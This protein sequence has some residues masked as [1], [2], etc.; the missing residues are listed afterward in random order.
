MIELPKDAEGKSIPLDTEEL[1]TYDG[2]KQDV[3]SFAYYRK[4]TDGKLRPIR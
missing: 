2:E 3:L 1:Y 4:K